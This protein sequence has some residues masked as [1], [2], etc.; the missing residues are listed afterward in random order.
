[1]IERIC[2]QGAL[3]VKVE[4]ID[5]V[6]EEEYSIFEENMRQVENLIKTNRQANRVEF[7]LTKEN[8]PILNY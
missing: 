7:G 3:V 1:M 4:H 8:T 5:Q 2:E 6:S